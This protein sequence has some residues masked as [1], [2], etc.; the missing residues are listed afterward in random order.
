MPPTVA[1]SRAP[2]STPYCQP[3]SAACRC[4]RASGTPACA[5]ICPVRGSTEPIASS[6]RRSSTSSPCSGT[7]PP[8]RPVLPPCGTIG[9]RSALHTWSTAAASSTDPGRI[10]AGLAPRNRPVQST[11]LAT[12]TSGS[13]RTC[14]APTVS[15]N[16]ASRPDDTLIVVDATAG[17][18]RFRVP[19]SGRASAGIAPRTIARRHAT[20]RRSQLRPDRRV[21]ARARRRRRPGRR[22]ESPQ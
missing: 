22:L 9:V 14:A 20:T 4:S 18:A 1:T 8:T 21:D 2:R 10:T 13:V 17:C 3:A 7:E 5:V 11:T 12:M 6:R 19:R 15:R 16:A